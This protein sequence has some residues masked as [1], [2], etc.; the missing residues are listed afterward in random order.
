MDV[1][2]QYLAITVTESAADTLTFQKVETGG[3]LFERR[4]MVIHRIA[5]A[6]SVTTLG[7]LDA[8][9]DRLEMGLSLSNSLTTI[10]WTDPNILDLLQIGVVDFGTA[11]SGAISRTP[12]VTDLSMLPGGGIIV[13]AYPLYGFVRGTSLGTAAVVVLRAYYTVKELE[14]TEFVE[15]V[16]AL[17]VIS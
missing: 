10:P 13:P 11:A 15:L 2:S 16:E 8:A 4:A 17:R 5:Y 7:L 14:P 1:F 9:A 6:P 12:W 3:F